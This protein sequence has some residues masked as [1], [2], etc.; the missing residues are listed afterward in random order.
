[1]AKARD[2]E[3]IEPGGQHRSGTTGGSSVAPVTG[4]LPDYHAPPPSLRRWVFADRQ[5]C[6]VTTSAGCR[7]IRLPKA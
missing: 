4:I 6:E 5:Q 2:P 3:P 1:M 7:P